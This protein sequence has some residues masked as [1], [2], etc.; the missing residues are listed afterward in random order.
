MSRKRRVN[1]HHDD[2]VDRKSYLPILYLLSSD[3]THFGTALQL[4]QNPLLDELWEGDIQMV[5]MTE[6]IDKP[7]G[8][9]WSISAR[10]AEIFLDYCVNRSL[11]GVATH[12]IMDPTYSILLNEGERQLATSLQGFLDALP[13]DAKGTPAFR[14]IA[15][16]IDD[17]GGDYTDKVLQK[18]LKKA[19]KAAAAAT[20]ANVKKLATSPMW[21]AIASKLEQKQSSAIGTPSSWTSSV[22]LQQSKGKGKGKAGSGKWTK[23]GPPLPPP[24]DKTSSSST[25][26][27]I[28]TSSN[29]PS[30]ST[31]PVLSPRS[32]ADSSMSS[33]SS[34]ATDDAGIDPTLD[35]DLDLMIDPI[36]PLFDDETS[37]DTDE[38]DPAEQPSSSS[39][40][41]T[42]ALKKS[43]PEK[44]KIT[45]STP[46][47]A[48]P[49]SSS[50]SPPSQPPAKQEPAK[51]PAVVLAPK[52]PEASTPSPIPPNSNLAS[53]PPTASPAAVPPVA[54]TTT[55][56]S[57]SATE[58]ARAATPVSTTSPAASL[59][60]L[61]PAT[62]LSAPPSSTTDSA[63]A[64]SPA[65][66]TTPSPKASSDPEAPAAPKK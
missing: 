55:Q 21:T 58:S 52:E 16:V 26:T 40:T 17:L 2:P 22:D 24:V 30:D 20:K 57:A 62:S 35:S 13:S 48:E 10:R 51:P 11:S 8:S 7:I 38:V 37:T 18:Q 19:A 33:G 15:T 43:G 3:S 12:H 65:A 44:S 5:N 60:A 28:A 6:S 63:Q 9:D 34:V 4:I 49:S 54:S 64:K 46:A 36:F 61:A 39:S 1:H 23:T 27:A 14:K 41:S 56:P 66:T 31:T 59:A 25:A 29:Q 50:T 32:E 53:A 45:V 47:V 42:G